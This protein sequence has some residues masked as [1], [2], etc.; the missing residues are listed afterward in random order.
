MRIFSRSELEKAVKLDTDALSVIRNGFIALAEN[1]VA[2]PPI[3]SMEVAKH[4][5]V[6]V[7][8]ENGVH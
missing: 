3:L 2:I 4:N 1:R 7:L 8:S 5:G 6:V